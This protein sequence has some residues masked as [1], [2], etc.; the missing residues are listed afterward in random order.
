MSFVLF[1]LILWVGLSFGLG[2]LVGRWLRRIEVS[3]QR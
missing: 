2:P 1:M 3:A